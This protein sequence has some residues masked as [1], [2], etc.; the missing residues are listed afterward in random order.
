MLIFPLLFIFLYIQN[1]SM[2]YKNQISSK[3]KI[4]FKKNNMNLFCVEN[5]NNDNF[6]NNEIFIPE[7]IL[8]YFSDQKNTKSHSLSLSFC[9]DNEFGYDC[10]YIYYYNDDNNNDNKLLLSIK[11]N[12]IKYNHVKYLE[13]LRNN[14]KL[15]STE[16]LHDKNKYS[17]CLHSNLMNEF[18]I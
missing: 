11:N 12:F 6:E 10:R 4:L 1:Y 5:N 8:Q 7:S 15:I 14:N 16:S 18:G 17:V 2:S 3:D 13:Q 9:S